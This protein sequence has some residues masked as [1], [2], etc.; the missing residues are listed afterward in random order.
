MSETC[1]LLPVG[2]SPSPAGAVP[3]FSVRPPSPAEQ[4]VLALLLAGCS[5]KEIA[6]QLDR[7][8]HTVKNQV[9]SLFRKYRVSS[10]T[11]LMALWAEA[12]ALPPAGTCQRPNHA[13]NGLAAHE[14]QE[15]HERHRRME[16]ESIGA[17]RPA[18]VGRM[19]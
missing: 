2:G 3:V 5:N 16:S 15:T 1:T 4:R 7:A 17:R 6:A 8:E 19:G 12:G 11:R 18:P 14:A 10:R 13:T 9:A